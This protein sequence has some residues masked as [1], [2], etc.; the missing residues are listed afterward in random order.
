MQS[1]TTESQTNMRHDTDC[2]PPVNGVEDEDTASHAS[3]VDGDH[4]RYL[5]AKYVSL[6]AYLTLGC[7]LNTRNDSI[8]ELAI[9]SC[10]NKHSRKSLRSGSCQTGSRSCHLYKEKKFALLD[11]ASCIHHSNVGITGLG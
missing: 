10:V 4:A 9:E 2:T 6:R 11:K 8:L 1:A 5:Y 3:Y 7:S